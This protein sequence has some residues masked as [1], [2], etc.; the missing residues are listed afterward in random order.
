[1]RLAERQD[2]GTL[3]LTTTVVCE[4][5]EG[6]G[7]GRVVA[8]LEGGYVPERVGAGAMTVMRALAGWTYRAPA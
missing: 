3:Y 2:A 4:L 8:A 7:H 6:A 5:A 1:M